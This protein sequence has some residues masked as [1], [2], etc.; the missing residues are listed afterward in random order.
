MLGPREPPQLC[1]WEVTLRHLLYRE[2]AEAV[3]NQWLPTAALQKLVATSIGAL[4]KAKRTWARV[5][6]PAAAFVASAWR[7]GWK[8]S[9]WSHATDDRGQ[10]LEF[11]RDAP[12]YVRGVVFQSARRWRWRRIEDK[13]PGLAAGGG[14][15]G[16]S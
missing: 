13:F 16:R 12:S 14:V 6:G 7:L 4:S 1:C 11:S 3:W 8:V 10:T 9:E 15:S 2:W 5:R